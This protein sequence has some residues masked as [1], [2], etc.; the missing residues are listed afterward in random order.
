[1]TAIEVAEAEVTL[2]VAVPEIDPDVAVMVTLPFATACTSPLVGEVVLTVAMAI[3]EE[4][5]V[6]LPVRFCWLPSL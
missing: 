4:A 1:M 5:Q 3:F 6:A 2:S